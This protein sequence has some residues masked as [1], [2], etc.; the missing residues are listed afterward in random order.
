MV[1]VVAVLLR[2]GTCA[3]IYTA[4]MAALLICSPFVACTIRKN[5]NMIGGSGLK[6]GGCNC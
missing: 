3:V 2:H 1:V 4:T 5:V 6:R